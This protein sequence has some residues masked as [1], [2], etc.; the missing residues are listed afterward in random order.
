MLLD[1]KMLLLLPR[2][3]SRIRSVGSRLLATSTTAQAASESKPA[4]FVLDNATIFPFGVP[5]NEPSQALFRDTDWVIGDKD[6]WAILSPSSSPSKSHLLSTI[7]AHTRFHP[8]SSGSHPILESLPLVAR[9]PQEGPPR[10]PIVSDIIQLVSFK[11]RLQGGAFEDY[12]A[13]YYSIRDEDKLTLRQHLQK[14]VPYTA[15]PEEDVILETAKLL[16]MED[17]LELPMVTL[18]NGQTR[19]ARICKA[20]LAKPELLILEE[21]YSKFSRTSLLHLVL[22]NGPR[23]WSRRCFTNDAIHSSRA[24]PICS[25]TSGPP[26][27]PTSRSSSILRLPCGSDC[28]E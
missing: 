5:S 26:C 4:V 8:P 1:P 14:S 21:P 22:N 11:T 9:D 2:S 28:S 25:S 24:T 16:E 20:L 13:R 7:L 19:R 3:L 6:C 23:S 27:P 15:E 10:L 12:T 17:F 18:S